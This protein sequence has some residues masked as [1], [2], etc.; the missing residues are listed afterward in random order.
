MAGMGEFV[1]PSGNILRG[2]EGYGVIQF[3]GTFSTLSFKVPTAE[4]WSAFTV[5]LKPAN[6]CPVSVICNNNN[7]CEAGES[8]NCPDCTNGGTDDKD[9]CGLSNST[10][11]VCKK[12]IN[13]S[14]TT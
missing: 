5:G 6:T 2:T 9:H 14:T 10:Q 13:N 3:S 7:T 12:D 1:N 8:C 11:M 4:Y